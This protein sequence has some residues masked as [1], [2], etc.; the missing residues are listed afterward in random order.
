[1]QKDTA[2]VSRTATERVERVPIAARLSPEQ[3]NPREQAT[4]EGE[5]LIRFRDPQRG[6]CYLFPPLS[7]REDV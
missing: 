6:V 1:M 3:W 4:N 7:I 2:R 5:P